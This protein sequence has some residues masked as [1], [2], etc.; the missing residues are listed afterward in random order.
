MAERD[1]R[2]D[3]EPDAPSG[4][5][6][7][8]HVPSPTALAAEAASLGVTPPGVVPAKEPEIPG[9]DELLRIGDAEVDPLA[10]AYVGDEAPGFGMPTPDQDAV[11]AT[12]RAYGVTEADSGS[13]KP[14]AEIAEARDRRRAFAEEPEPG[15]E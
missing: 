4:E 9:Q 11:D 10:N 3:R 7:P 13:L 1:K 15:G 2:I 6:E 12:G 14:T 8:A 5:D